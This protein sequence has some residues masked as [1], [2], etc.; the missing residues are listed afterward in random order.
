MACQAGR[1][2]P[3]RGRVVGREARERSAWR[4]RR[5]VLRPAVALQSALA[6]WLGVSTVAAGIGYSKVAAGLAWFANGA[7]RR[8]LFAI[9]VAALS[10]FAGVFWAFNTFGT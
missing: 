3:A 5:E 7:H 4:V 9:V 2:T 8:R 10:L 1:W 6:I